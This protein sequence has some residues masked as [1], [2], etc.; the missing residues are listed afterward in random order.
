MCFRGVL[1][2]DCVGDVL[3]VF[4]SSRFS[5]ELSHW[6][7]CFSSSLRELR[8][9]RVGFD[10]EVVYACEEVVHALGFSVYRL[11]NSRVSKQGHQALLPCLV[12]VTALIG[13]CAS[14]AYT[15]NKNHHDALSNLLPTYLR[16]TTTR[17]L[18][19]SALRPASKESTSASPYTPP[20]M[21]VQVI[22]ARLKSA[23]EQCKAG[24]LRN[25][26]GGKKGGMGRV[27]L[28]A[29]SS[30]RTP[31]HGQVGLV[32]GGFPGADT[33]LGDGVGGGGVMGHVG[34][35]CVPG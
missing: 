35:P 33:G 17:P 2:L 18:T 12:Q 4:W 7:A 20:H 24:D 25:A 29:I 6:V 1:G 23:T 11:C 19:P 32:I 34:H 13:S 30:V 28:R 16:Y 31:R 3:W 14:R 15:A 27:D 5:R 21:S 10:A 26:G 8:W 22:P 9:V